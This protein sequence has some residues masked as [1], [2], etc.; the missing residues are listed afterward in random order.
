MAT[1]QDYRPQITVRGDV[2]GDLQRLTDCIDIDRILDAVDKLRA[3]L[4]QSN[5]EDRIIKKG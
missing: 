5:R 4:D 3:P 1:L 2:A